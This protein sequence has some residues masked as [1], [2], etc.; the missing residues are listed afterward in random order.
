MTI[1]FRTRLFAIA[2]LIV[3]AVLTAVM[4]LGWS[5][6]SKVEVDRLDDRLCMEARRI[7]TQTWGGGGMERAERQD[8][9]GRG[10]N[11]GGDHGGDR[12]GRNRNGDLQRLEADVALK[13]RLGSVSQLML[14]F[15]PAGR[16]GS[17]TSLPGIQSAGWRNAPLLAD[18]PWTPAR[19]QDARAPPP[20]EVD[21]NPDAN[22]NQPASDGGPVADIP[23]G[24]P[25]R[26]APDPEQ[27]AERPAAGICTLASFASEGREWRAARYALPGGQGV[28]AADLA[29]TRAELQSV[30]QRALAIVVPLSLLLT[31]LGAWLLASLTMRPVNRLRHAMQR[32]TPQALDQRLPSDGEDHEFKALI[33]E[34]NTMLDRLE[35]SFHQASRFS[36]DAAHELKT[37]LTIL[38]GRI[39]QA[40]GRSGSRAIQVDL[41][42]ML[43]EVGRL[44]AITRKLLLLSQADAGRL[45]LHRLPLDLTSLL[46]ALMADAQMLLTHQTITATI[47]PGLVLQADEVLLRQLFN[48][49][50][51]NAVRYCQP[52]GW[53]CLHACRH[54]N[55]VALVF[56]N[57]AAGVRA[58]DRS[59]FFER[60]FRGD[61]AHNS[62]IEGSG[63]GL[64][65]AREIARAH[66]GDLTLQP[67]P[68]EEVSLRLWLPCA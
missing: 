1:S 67:G 23:L 30:V 11:S 33:G 58:A 65:L 10:D 41:S 16:A 31:A 57:Q 40:V 8:R 54:D 38:Q 32:M 20:S 55:G 44:S 49:L 3:G 52:N 26:D 5:S 2:A 17:D 45:A 62:Q 6:V 7:A 61:P 60:F 50:I 59:R 4:A 18:L 15:D 53:V 29:S 56:T 21:F 66:G 27:R 43:D 9:N 28:V 37:P 39:E 34:Y 48:N 46:E 12:M 68:A 64:S 25:G 42:E 24:A 13:L 14:R 19:R 47:A 35:A 36:S 51:N 22:T 63:L